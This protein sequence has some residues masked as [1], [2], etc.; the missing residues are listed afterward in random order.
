[1]IIVDQ[2][3]IAGGLIANAERNEDGS[4]TDK[5]QLSMTASNLSNIANH[6][7]LSSP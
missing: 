4:L 7:A 6:L 1:M 3:N 5:G 2:V